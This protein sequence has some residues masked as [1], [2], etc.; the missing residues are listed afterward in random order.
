MPGVH[1]HEMHTHETH[2]HEVHAHETHGLEICTHKMRDAGEIFDLSLSVPM[3][4]RTG[5][6]G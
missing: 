5:E 6:L 3:S 1:A 4:L 2:A